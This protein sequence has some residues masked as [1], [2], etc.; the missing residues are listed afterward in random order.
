[1][2]N[3][4]LARLADPLPGS[5]TLF[6]N[7]RHKFFCECGNSYEIKN[8]EYT[9]YNKI[10]CIF[11]NN[12]VSYVKMSIKQIENVIN[13]KLRLFENE[14]FLNLVLFEKFIGVNL[15]TKKLY[16]KTTKFKFTYNKRH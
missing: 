13:K 12:E 4:Y 15:K 3:S 7:H 9:K 8:L 6:T 14:T 16:Y 2:K 5:N 1:M 10:V 11:C